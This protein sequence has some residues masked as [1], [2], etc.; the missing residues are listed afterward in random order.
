MWGRG[1]LRPIE[2]KGGVF[3]HFEVSKLG[4]REVSYLPERHRWYL[5]R[6]HS[7]QHDPRGTGTPPSPLVTS[8][9]KPA[10]GPDSCLCSLL[11]QGQGGWGSFGGLSFAADHDGDHEPSK[12]HQQTPGSRAAV[13][14][15]V[16]GRDL[17]Q[18]LRP[19]KT[20]QIFTFAGVPSAVTFG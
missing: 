4:F 5:S 7:Q 10:G 6:R 14:A 18:S 12:P 9:K 11:L 19:V 1:S 15:L 13:S 8:W 2:G 17:N 16:R 20:G 3:F